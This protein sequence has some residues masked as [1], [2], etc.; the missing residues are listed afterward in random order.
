M[1]SQT[2]SSTPKKMSLKGGE[3]QNKEILVLPILIGYALVLGKMSSLGGVALV[4]YNA[5]GWLNYRGQSRVIFWN[6]ASKT[7][8]T[9]L[10]KQACIS[11]LQQ[12][13]KACPP[14]LTKR[15]KESSS[16]SA[17]CSSWCFWAA[18]QWQQQHSPH[19]HFFYHCTELM[20][21][22]FLEARRQIAKTSEHITSLFLFIFFQSKIAI[23]LVLGKMSF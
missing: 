8:S 23:F 18:Q 15:W 17:L 14:L 22:T 1:L 19:L 7:S 9:V 4:N 10:W 5:W 3:S 20:Y 12:P 6:F 13:A 2:T 16:I 21:Q 11:L